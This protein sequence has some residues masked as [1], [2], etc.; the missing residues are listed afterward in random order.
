MS[1]G[2]DNVKDFGLS[3][4]AGGSVSPLRLF[5]EGLTCLC[6]SDPSILPTG[7]E[8]V[9]GGYTCLPYLAL[10]QAFHG[11]ERWLTLESE[12]QK[13]LERQPHRVTLAQNHGTCEGSRVLLPATATARGGHCTETGI[14]QS[15]PHD[16]VPLPAACLVT[17]YMLVFI[18]LDVHREAST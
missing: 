17:G 6:H 15:D 7:G 11:D 9:G 10:S 8:G 16:T 4:G 14:A 13:A 1:L 3:S 5:L 2:R 18:G 12:V